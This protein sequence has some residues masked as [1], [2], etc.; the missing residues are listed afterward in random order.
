MKLTQQTAG[1]DTKVCIASCPTNAPFKL[2]F[3]TPN[4]KITCVAECANNPNNIA[5]NF[6]STDGTSCVASCSPA[7]PTYFNKYNANSLVVVEQCVPSCGQFAV[8]AG[9]AFNC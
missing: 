6:V 2:T 4:T 7:S 5:M 8:L 9:L 3:T 1:V